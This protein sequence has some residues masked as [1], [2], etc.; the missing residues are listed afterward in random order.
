MV[1]VK[2]DEEKFL[3]ALNEYID[4]KEI[5]Q[6]VEAI[7]L[8]PPEEKADKTLGLANYVIQK[9]RLILDDIGQL[10]E[11][12]EMMDSLVKFLDDCIKLPFFL[13]P[14]DGMMIRGALTFAAGYAAKYSK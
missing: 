9:V 14:F 2:F 8:C 10:S 5:T 6:Y 3:A 13:E 12:K 4:I 7:K 1:N 11:N